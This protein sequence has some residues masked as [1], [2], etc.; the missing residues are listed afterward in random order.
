M[1]S[2]SSMPSMPGKL[3]LVQDAAGQH[4]EPA[5]EL[6]APA[7]GDLPPT[8]LVVPVGT[9]HVGLEQGERVEVELAGQEL[10]VLE[11]LGGAG[12][13]LGRHEARL[14]EQGQV[15]VGLDVAHAAR[16]P[17]PVP[18]ATEV[19]R[20][21]DDPDVVDPVLAEVDGRE[22]PGEAAAHDDHRR[23]L[24]HRIPGEARLDER[25]PVET[26]RSDHG[27]GPCPR[28]GGASAV[29]AG[30]ARAA[31]RPRLPLRPCPAP[32]SPSSTVDRTR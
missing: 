26:R 29:P 6:V 11:D 12:V 1:P 2:K 25:V 8:C 13:V 15:Y 4:Q 31:P 21:L 27:T 5:R 30:T 24:D 7:G 18:G 10:G 19:A 32:L 17:V 22:H 20:L 23:L 14:L 9:G 3:G 28:V 16:V